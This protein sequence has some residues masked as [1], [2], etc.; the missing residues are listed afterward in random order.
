MK[1]ALPGEGS[2]EREP[3]WKE[4]ARHAKIWEKNVLRRWNKYKGP[5]PRWKAYTAEQ[6][7]QGERVMS[8][9]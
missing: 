2:S 7:E 5:K 9:M 1:A 4:G 8:E 6:S 3:E